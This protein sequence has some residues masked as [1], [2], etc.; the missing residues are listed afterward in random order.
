MTY[1]IFKKIE[2]P[3][4]MKI[5]VLATTLGAAGL[6]FAQSKAP[7]ATVASRAP[8]T[9]QGIEA[10]VV[11][12]T[13]WP[14]SEG[15]VIRTS[16]APAEVRLKDGTRIF[17]PPSSR[18]VVG[19][20]IPLSNTRAAV[21]AD[22]RVRAVTGAP[23]MSTMKTQKGLAAGVMN[24]LDGGAIVLSES[25]VQQY[26][27]ASMTAPRLAGASASTFSLA[28]LLNSFGVNSPVATVVA[29][30][31][32]VPGAVLNQSSN[33]SY[34]ISGI[35]AAVGNNPPEP[36]TIVITPPVPPTPANPNPPPA[37]FQAF[38][39]AV[40]VLPT[41]A[42]PAP[43]VPPPAA[44]VSTVTAPPP[45]GDIVT[46]CKGTSLQPSPNSATTVSLPTSSSCG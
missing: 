5:F 42:A 23:S 44:A 19:P 3:T 18:Y 8:I 12:S 34:Y 43:P 36:I 33:G 13:A 46:G 11:G 41:P 25:T 1:P 9:V 32:S 31:L 16:S 24:L 10:P 26:A 39:E 27:A 28:Q 30:A 20:A 29:Q 40:V 14:V 21:G 37:T 38:P 15:D 4:A 2:G 45:G 35:Q 17:V 7:V 6:T 22:L